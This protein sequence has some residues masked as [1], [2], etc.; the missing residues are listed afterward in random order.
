MATAHDIRS[1]FLYSSAQALFLSSP[2]TSQHLLRERVQM[3][4]EDNK[5]IPDKMGH[6]CLACGNF[7]LSGWTTSTKLVSRGKKSTANINKRAPE[8]SRVISKYLK[9]STCGRTTKQRSEVR[10]NKQRARHGQAEPPNLDT[11]APA[12]VADIKPTTPSKL[13]SKQRAKARKDREG[14]QA[15]LGRTSQTAPT[16]RLNLM[17]MMKR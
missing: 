5:I 16:P 1:Q 4:R 14:L 12:V 15:L 7:L 17:D 6:V 3:D 2:S 8:T 9:C 10:V 11:K 13:T